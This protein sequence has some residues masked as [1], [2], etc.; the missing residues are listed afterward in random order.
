MEGSTLNIDHFKEVETQRW[1]ELGQ[2]VCG[3]QQGELIS[4]F[5]WVQF[6][7]TREFEVEQ[8]VINTQRHIH[9]ED[10]RNQVRQETAYWEVIEKGELELKKYDKLTKNELYAHDD[11]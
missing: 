5:V 11:G 1:C 9:E 6:I 10:D 4:L 7:V 8:A 3:I 2:E